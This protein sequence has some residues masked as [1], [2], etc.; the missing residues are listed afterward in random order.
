LNDYLLGIKNAIIWRNSMKIRL[1]KKRSEFHMRNGGTINMRKY[2]FAVLLAVMAI[3]PVMANPDDWVVTA[4]VTTV[5]GTNVPMLVNFAL[6][7]NGGTTTQC[8]AGHWINYHPY[9][10]AGTDTTSQ[11]QNV[12][13][14]YA[15]LLAARLSGQT[16]TIYGTNT[17]DASL[18]RC[19]ASYVL[20]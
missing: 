10:G 14:V 7:Q 3:T 15:L 5:E 4:H 16:V 9:A 19:V 2:L 18:G 8:A 20:M 17:P 13:A 1:R 6:D 11:Q 12:K